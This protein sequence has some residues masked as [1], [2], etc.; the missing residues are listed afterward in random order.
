[1]LTLAALRAKPHTSNSQLKTFIQCPRKYFL[2]YIKG[3]IPAF[4][5]LALVFGSAWHETVGQYL[6]RPVP[7]DELRA[8]LRDGLVCGLDRD[9]VPVLFDEDEQD[10]STVIDVA[11]RM[12]DVFL[13]RVPLP[14]QVHGV[15]MPFR[16]KLVHPV[17]GEVR[18]VPLVGALDAVVEDRGRPVVWELKTGKKRW[19]ADQLDFDLQPTAYGMAA[20][21]LGY[22]DARLTLIVAT[23][24]KTPDVQVEQLVRHRREELELVETAFAVARAVK[25][26]VDYPNRGWQ[27]RTC[28][29]ALACGS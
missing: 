13:A 18:P 9:D 28:P 10:I 16:L 11:M 6:A 26:G 25:A 1:M 19:S 21:T 27:C 2:Q 8:H 17:T 7:V 24:G 22:K 20:R 29:Y 3:V 5:P 15:E 12:L 4:R 14:E 23:K